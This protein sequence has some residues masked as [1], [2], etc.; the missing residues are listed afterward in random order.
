MSIPTEI[1]NG[2]VLVGFTLDIK[3]DTLTKYLASRGEHHAARARIYESKVEEI[4]KLKEDSD[5]ETAMMSKG[6]GTGDPVESLRSSARK[7]NKRAR[8]FSFASEH[9][10]K[11][12]TYRLSQSDLT[13]LEI[14]PDR[15]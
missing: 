5:D 11:G 9:I 3:S 4:S 10:A 6:A 7:H 2:S 15:Y 12:R 1:E 14:Y 8:F 13:S